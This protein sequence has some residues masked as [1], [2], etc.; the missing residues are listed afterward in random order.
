MLYVQRPLAGLGFKGR[1]C[2][3]EMRKVHIDL[4]KSGDIIA[5]PIFQENGNVLLGVGIELTDRYIRRLRDMGIDYLFI[6][7]PLT[8]GIEPEEPV[9]EATR[10]EAVNVIY[11]TMSAFKSNDL[12][13]GR[14][15][16][17]NIGKKFRD[18]FGSIMTDLSTRKNII[19]NLSTIHSTDSYLF[20]HSVNVAVIAGIIGLAKGLN[21]I[22]LEELGIGAMLFDIGMTKMPEKLLKQPEQLTKEERALLETHPV[23][24][25]N[26]LRRY[27]DISIVSA[28]CALQHH[29]RFDGSGYPRGLKGNDIHLYGQIVGLA[30]MYDALTSPRPYRKRYRTSEA[31]EFL[32]AAGGTY[33]DHELIKLFCSHISIYP[34]ATMLLLNTGQTV[35]V[36]QNSE[37][38]LHRPVVRV[39]READGSVPKTPYQF[40]L[41]D[42]LH[43][44]IVKEL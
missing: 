24:G 9:S 37:L 22:Q 20:Q 33:F 17:P 14:I 42:E 21:R 5:K 7:D 27:H 23:E 2:C 41:K 18:V 30:D 34:I 35:V 25:F 11:E 26:I 13:K 4:V 19:E 36:V 16:A 38:A 44:T 40:D 28:H 31:I 43:I 39:I 12:S 1:R 32:F 15:I 29:E 8:E 3:A 10:R 6:E